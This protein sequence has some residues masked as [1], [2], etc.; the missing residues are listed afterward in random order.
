MCGATIGVELLLPA[1]LVPVGVPRLILF[2][3]KGG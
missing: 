2:T 1:A 3:S